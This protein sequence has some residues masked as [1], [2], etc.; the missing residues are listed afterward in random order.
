MPVSWKTLE[1]SKA[2]H[3]DGRKSQEEQNI[4]ES[5]AN[6]RAWYIENSIM[7]IEAVGFSRCGQ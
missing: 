6:E 4:E 7:K 2:T 5:H 3:L 1:E